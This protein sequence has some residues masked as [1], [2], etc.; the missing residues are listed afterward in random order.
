[1][2]G[3][4]FDIKK[5]LETDKKNIENGKKCKQESK[6]EDKKHLEVD[7]KNIEKKTRKKLLLI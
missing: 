7:E 3:F 1:M 2:E 6:R 5:K 4:A